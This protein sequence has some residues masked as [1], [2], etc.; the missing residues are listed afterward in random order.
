MSWRIETADTLALLRELP[1]R[2]VQTCIAR[3]P[4]DRAADRTLAILAEVQRVLREDGTLWL[5][6]PAS[7]QQS[8]LAALRAQGWKQQAPPSWADRPAAC[9]R[10]SAITPLLFSKRARYFYE[11]GASGVQRRPLAL[12]CQL[13]GGRY[14]HL[15]RCPVALEREQRLG[16]LRR[17]VLAGSSRVACGQCGAP[18]RRARRVEQGRGLSEPTCRHR[19]RDGRCLVLDPFY[20]PELPTAVAALC[21]GRSFLG[22]EDTATAGRAR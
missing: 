20:E 13:G 3:P 1:D 4:G 18:H 22:I 6:T 8:L 17:C 5:L 15:Q 2:L 10:G 14:W 16:V 9:S 21:G 11:E 19:D 7:P 12:S